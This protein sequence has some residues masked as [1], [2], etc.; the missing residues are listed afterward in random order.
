[1]LHVTML[2]PLIISLQEVLATY[3]LSDNTYKYVLF[4]YLYVC[5]WRLKDCFKMLV[6]L[7]SSLYVLLV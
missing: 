4:T 5:M 7:V 1:M 3:P 2:A 6:I